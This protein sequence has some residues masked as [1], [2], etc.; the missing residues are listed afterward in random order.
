V[1]QRPGTRYPPLPV[2]LAGRRVA[3]DRFTPWMTQFAP[4]ARLQERHELVHAFFRTRDAAEGARIAERLSA[5]FACFYETDRVRFDTA[6]LVLPIHAEPGA[7]CGRF[8]R[9]DATR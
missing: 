4:A 5:R 9:I 6:G 2:V 7:F 8:V 3:Y 1:L